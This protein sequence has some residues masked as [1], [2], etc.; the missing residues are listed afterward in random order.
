VTFGLEGTATITA[1]KAASANHLAAQ[2]TY[3]L[4]VLSRP[5]APFTAWL[6]H[7]D[8]AEVTLPAA[9]V[10]QNFVRALSGNCAGP[11]STSC[12]PVSSSTVT[13]TDVT[14]PVAGLDRTA[15]Y[16]L[17]NGASLGRPVAVDARRFTDAAIAPVELDGQ[18]WMIV[19]DGAEI[20]SS[21]DGRAW[22]QRSA[23]LPWTSRWGAS[24]VKFD[25]R[26]YFIAGRTPRTI[27]SFNDVWRSDDGLNWTRL[28]Q[29]A[30]FAV[31]ENPEVVVHDGRLWLIGGYD[32]D[33]DVRYNDVWS[34]TD[35]VSW[36]QETANAAF[37]PRHNHR[38]V[39]MNGRIWL[40]GGTG[41]QH[42]GTTFGD[43]WSSD[44]G[45]S[46]RAEPA[47]PFGARRNVATLVYRNRWYV[48]GG[49]N[50]TNFGDVWWT[51]DG[52]QWHPEPLVNTF[53][54]I[55]DAHLIP[56]RGRVWLLG[57]FGSLRGTHDFYS[58]A[59]FRSWRYEHTGVPFPPARPGRLV[60]FNGK[61]W[62][63]AQAIDGPMN[64]WWSV[65]G[66]EWTRSSGAS[67]I[68]P[69]TGF[70]VAVNNGRLWIQGGFRGQDPFDRLN[71]VWSTADG[72]TWT[73]ATANAPFEPRWLQEMFAMNGKLFMVG[74]IVPGVGQRGDVWSST[75]GASWTQETPLSAFGTRAGHQIVV[76]N[77]KAWLLGG[78]SQTIGMTGTI[79]SSL[80]AVSWTLEATDLPAT[81][82]TQH[83]AVA[84]GG[85]MWI[86]GGEMV[87]GPFVPLGDIWYS[88]DGVTWT[89]QQSGSPEYSARGYHGFA[90]HGGKLWIYGGE[91]VD[92]E[93]G[94]HDLFWSLEGTDWR[95][96]HHNVIEIPQ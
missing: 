46:W 10:G 37:S 54:G 92:G 86:T 44:D 64:V 6:S 18:L 68:P 5:S 59:D 61:L 39:S 30:P 4:N 38:V 63:I 74:G 96:R 81:G 35:G 90:S 79:W 88:A 12:A 70:T 22:I 56:Y 87:G 82:R 91:G 23:S 53:G 47:P 26:L 65:D 75:D 93:I 50:G 62:M 32:I 43:V 28:V 19:D 31:R 48:A 13:T 17:Q 67:V 7:T 40:V 69:R 89:Q 55:T 11:L 14:D 2:A 1:T 60:S 36:T 76:F 34:S 15:Q 33:T 94:S 66:N 25:N 8:P 21:A 20:W 3:V 41:T 58:T 71:D 78:S 16:W 52:L 80:D 45:V 72:E 77:G 73:Q 57:G 85:R 27:I 95:Y 83:R 51:E 84:H 9:A 42:D 49:H 24:L 29:N